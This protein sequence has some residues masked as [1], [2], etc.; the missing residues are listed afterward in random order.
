MFENLDIKFL[1]GFVSGFSSRVGFGASESILN[2]DI[3][4]PKYKCPTA[5]TSGTVG[6]CCEPDQSCTAGYEGQ[7]DCENAGGT[8]HGDK[9][10]DDNP[11]SCPEC[12]EQ[13]K[14]E[15]K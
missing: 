5:T 3:V 6:V 4:L 15:A 13:S 1:G 7:T 11:C 8:W 12:N 2:V 9:T 14:Y 10:C